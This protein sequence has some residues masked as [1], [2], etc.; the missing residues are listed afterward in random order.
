M[1]AKEVLEEYETRIGELVALQGSITRTLSVIDGMSKTF[2]VYGAESQHITDRCAN[3]VIE[4]ENQL[5]EVEDAIDSLAAAH[6]DAIKAIDKLDSPAHR[7]I[8][9][10][11]Y[12]NGMTIY[13]VAKKLSI[14][15]KAVYNRH[16]AALA[17]LENLIN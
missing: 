12:L 8:L 10:W 7:E 15:T 9:R 16:D 5:E 11:V 4:Y 3:L 1:K 14:T 6:Q 17:M 2:I 13:E